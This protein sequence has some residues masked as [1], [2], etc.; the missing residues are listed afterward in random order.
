MSKI[1][2]GLEGIVIDNDDDLAAAPGLQTGGQPLKT[3]EGYERA[4]PFAN[5]SEAAVQKRFGGRLGF[6]LLGD[7]AFAP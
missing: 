4:R 3:R 7:S 6:H 1:P 2:L 5:R